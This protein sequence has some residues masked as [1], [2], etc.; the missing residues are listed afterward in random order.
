MKRS[1]ADF[2]DQIKVSAW[3]N[4]NFLPPN[5]VTICSNKKVWFTCPDPTCGHD[6]LSMVCNV[7]KKKGTWCPFCANRKICKDI[8]C[9]AC[10]PKTFYGYEDKTKVESW[11][12]RNPTKPWH[13]FLCSRE[14]AWFTCTEC[15][16]EFAAV[17]GDVASKS[18]SWCPFCS[19]NRLCVNPVESSICLS[20][21]FYSFEDKEKVSSWSPLNESPPWMVFVK[22]NKKYWFDCKKCR[23][24]FESELSNITSQGTWCPY[25]VS[26]KLCG[27]R[28]CKSCLPKTF[29][30]FSDK[31]KVESWSYEKNN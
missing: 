16:H 3:S 9:E 20:K 6:F 23:H 12:N 11:S 21:T 18:F 15:N 17:V 22:S 28:D 24:S 10:L 31:K 25:C 4:K 14:K 7:T 29:L 26:K 2:E 30:S 13:V 5:E 8:A 27:A 19:N 1:F